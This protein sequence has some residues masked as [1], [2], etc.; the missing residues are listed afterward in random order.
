M[1]GKTRKQSSPPVQTPLHLLQ[2]LTRTL[3]EHLMQACDQAQED[4]QKAL[5]KLDREQHKLAE[6]LEQIQEKLTPA[7]LESSGKSPEKLQGKVE[8]LTTRMTLLKQARH[9]AEE[10]I[11]QLQS[12]VR[13]TL[14]LAKGLERID[15]QAT[16]AIDKRNNPSAATGSPGKR[17]S[18][19]RKP[20][21]SAPSTT[22]S[23]SGKA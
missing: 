8:E 13:Q 17:R 2:V 3:N 21:A 18:R 20:A 19:S 12:D 14:R 7:N 5:D 1:T 23:S 10:Y 22:D 6:K 9:E 15:L 4:A 11:R 16:Q